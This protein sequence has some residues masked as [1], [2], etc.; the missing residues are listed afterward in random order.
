MPQTISPLAVAEA[1]AIYQPQRAWR[2]R[3][4]PVRTL[5]Y[6]VR[7]WLPPAD[8][9]ATDAAPLVLLHGWMDVAASWQFVVDAFSA[10]FVRARRIIAPD[11]RGF[12]LSRPSAPQDRY[13]FIDHLADLDHL[14]DTVAGTQPVDLVGHSMGGNVAMS[15]AG[16]RPQRIRRLVNL[17]GF[18]SPATRPEQAPARYARWMDETRRLREGGMALKTYDSARA[19]AQRLMKTNPR[20]PQDKALWLAHHWAAPNAQGRWEILGDAAH[21]VTSA[22]L[23]RLDE[24]LALY[25][26]ISA[27]VLSVQ[28]SENSLYG[29]WKERYTLDEYH[30][31]IKH[32]TR[33]Q[34]T[35]VPDC[36]HMLHHDQ[37]LAVARLIE[38][39]VEN[40]QP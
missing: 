19:V 15:Y 11:W 14:L 39:F 32:I 6:H 29:W 3:M 40:V 2:S 18:G 5:E 36:G 28:A 17:E 23:W 12:G 4:L 35:T 7:E 24:M 37:P 21:K 20:L 10:G 1:E 16:I 34:S 30:E 25:R 26:A 8:A 27:P 9:P 38:D 13:D 22:Q 33:C 31:R